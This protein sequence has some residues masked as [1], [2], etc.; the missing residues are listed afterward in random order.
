MWSPTECVD[1]ILRS[2]VDPGTL[3][4]RYAMTIDLVGHSKQ[5]L[6]LGPAEGH[7]A[8]AL[9]ARGCRVTGIE[10]DV[11]APALGE[12][13]DAGGFGAGGFDV[14]LASDVLAHL[15]DPLPVLRECRAALRPGGSVV[16]SV[17]NLTH[18]DVTLQRRAGGALHEDTGPLDHARLRFF[19][20]ESVE[21]L[22]RDAG[23]LMVDLRRVLV[24]VFQTDLAVRADSVADALLAEVLADDESETCQFV[25]RAVLDDGD[26]AIQNLAH[27]AVS[28]QTSLE[29]ER[30]ARVVAESEREA[31]LAL[32][33]DLERLHDVAVH[34]A[35]GFEQ[36]SED[37]RLDIEAM[38]STRSYRL[39]EPLRSL[40]GRRG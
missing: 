19:T 6:E 14:V 15:A 20:L 38:Q 18:A 17:P 9:V 27:R 37:R 1:K 4:A 33:E 11:T 23:L 35:R 24:P 30:A 10:I 2:E 34:H 29:R 13:F 3:N 28:L 31:A 36:L 32:V 5:V 22:V 12:G 39:L 21:G 25:V 26:A 40:F 7:V 8:D 16:L